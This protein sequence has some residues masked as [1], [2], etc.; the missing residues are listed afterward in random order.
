MGNLKALLQELDEAT[1][2]NCKGQFLRVSGGHMCVGAWDTEVTREQPC[3]P[4]SLGAPWCGISPLLSSA[5]PLAQGQ[6]A[7][8][9]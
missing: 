8:S 5:D 3:P 2:L 7:P 9:G 1:G 6:Q 4:L